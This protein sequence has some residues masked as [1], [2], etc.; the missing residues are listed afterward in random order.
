MGDLILF[1]QAQERRDDTLQ[2]LWDN[3]RQAQGV[4]Q[5][6]GDI[7]HGILA[8]KAWAAWLAAFQTVCA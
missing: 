7:K 2:A 1:K 5:R 3:Y 6:S 8:G 4:A